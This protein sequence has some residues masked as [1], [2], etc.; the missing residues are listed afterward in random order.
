MD[1]NFLSD[2]GFSLI[3]P[4][5]ISRY[6]SLVE[7]EPTISAAAD[8]RINDILAGNIVFTLGTSPD[9]L[10]GAEWDRTSRHW[11]DVSRRTVRQLLALGFTAAVTEGDRGLDERLR[12]EEYGPSVDRTKQRGRPE[13]RRLVQMR[14]K[15]PMEGWETGMGPSSSRRLDAR[16]MHK[17]RDEDLL[18]H[19]L[20]LSKIDV[21]WRKDVFSQ[22]SFRFFVRDNAQGIMGDHKAAFK[23]DHAMHQREIHHVFWFV[24]HDPVLQDDYASYREALIRRTDRYPNG[25]GMGVKLTSPI[26]RLTGVMDLTRHNLACHKVGTM[27][28]TNPTI[29]LQDQPKA[30]DPN[31]SGSMGL[32]VAAHGPGEGSAGQLENSAQLHS[33]FPARNFMLEEQERRFY[34]S[35]AL[36][37]EEGSSSKVAAPWGSSTGPETIEIT[38]G[39]TTVAEMPAGKAV[40]RQNPAQAVPYMMELL[41]LEKERVWEVMGQ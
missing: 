39:E 3:D 22:Q 14:N 38:V 19:V 16:D 1:Q 12:M 26:A 29:L 4:T 18:V 17:G 8:F 40:I 6:M 9:P 33:T 11:H 25:A 2:Q 37:R 23:G 7:T 31:E 13:N 30:V 20:D 34:E 32:N 27:L 10:R 41:Q 21:Y 5:L 15:G 36:R 28:M 24:T 35:Q